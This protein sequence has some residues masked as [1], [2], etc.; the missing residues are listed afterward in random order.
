MD[1]SDPDLSPTISSPTSCSQVDGLTINNPT[2]AYPQRVI[3]QEF[4]NNAD[5][6]SI[7]GNC[8]QLHY[9]E[10]HPEQG[11]YTVIFIFS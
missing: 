8:V 2:T 3:L 11:V 10:S 5:K 7:H 4:R 1:V 6:E 9:M